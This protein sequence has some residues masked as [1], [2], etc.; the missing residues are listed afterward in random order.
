MN[1]ELVSTENVEKVFKTK[2]GPFKALRGVNLKV[3]E[4]EF[5]AIVGP[6]G[7]GKGLPANYAR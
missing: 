3:N 2:A 1:R 6:S 7:S 5:V 4:G